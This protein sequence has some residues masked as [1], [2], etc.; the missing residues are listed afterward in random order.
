MHKKPVGSTLRGLVIA[1]FVLATVA[2]AARADTL[3]TTATF[4]VLNYWVQNDYESYNGICGGSYVSGGF[5]YS[6]Q[7]TFSSS[8][9]PGVTASVL[10]SSI[11]PGISLYASGSYVNMNARIS[12]AYAYSEFATAGLIRVSGGGTTAVSLN[13][14][15][16]NT[17]SG[18]WQ[19]APSASVSLVLEWGPYDAST[20]FVTVTNTD[21]T[22]YT[23]GTAPGDLGLNSSRSLD[24]P[25]QVSDGDVLLLDLSGREDGGN[26]ATVTLTDP[27]TLELP[28]GATY[29]T[30]SG[31]PD[32]PVETV[33]ASP[34]PEPPS[35]ILLA[36]ALLGVLGLGWHRRLF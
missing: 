22:G 5:E 18:L 12:D 1:V 24:V 27:L 29:T 32:L 9:C 16:V 34:V 2:P 7:L 30:L 6:K 31:G 35:L 8:A 28:G 21:T 26:G 20:G 17:A 23:W 4:K 33:G 14:V 10:S 3:P 25:I 19:Y 11:G 36:S 13:D 15:V